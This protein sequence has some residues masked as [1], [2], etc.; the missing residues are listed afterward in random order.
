MA[1]IRSVFQLLVLFSAFFIYKT[2]MGVIE[3]NANEAFL[4]L[5]LTVI[6]IISLTIAYFVIKRW[7]KR[8]KI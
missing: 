4:W 3:N 8:Q 1:K 6:Y 2:I 7:E 5:I